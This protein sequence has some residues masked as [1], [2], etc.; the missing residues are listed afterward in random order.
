MQK[1]AE[2][3]GQPGIVK[4]FDPAEVS[5]IEVCD[6]LDYSPSIGTKQAPIFILQQEIFHDE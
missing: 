1:Y 3:S 2:D 6:S 5:L 4:N